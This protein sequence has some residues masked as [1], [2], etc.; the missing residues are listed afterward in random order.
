MLALG[1]ADQKDP[2]HL[3]RND[4]CSALF[5]TAL[6]P[7]RSGDHA[8]AD[9]EDLAAWS[10]RAPK[11]CPVQP[12]AG[13]VDGRDPPRPHGRPGHALI[14]LRTV[15][16]LR[17]L[18]AVLALTS[19]HASRSDGWY[20]RHILAHRGDGWSTP[21]NITLFS[22][23]MFSSIRSSNERAHPSSLFTVQPR[24]AGT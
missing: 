11:R 15:K 5:V 7:I 2:R 19:P 16:G 23:G 8:A 12:A 4:D 22:N 6:G 17:T 20:R 10:G 9:D 14:F 13:L 3:G 18:Q 24:G 21:R 1:H